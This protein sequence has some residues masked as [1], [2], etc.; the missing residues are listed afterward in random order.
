M[1]RYALFL[2]LLSLFSVL[3]AQQFVEPLFDVKAILEQDLD[4]RI[5]N[6]SVR[7]GI[8]LQEVE[9][10]SEIYQGKPVRIYGIVGFPEGAKKL[11][12]IFWSQAGMAP[13]NKGMP[14]MFAKRGYVCMCITLPHKIWNPWG[15]FNTKNP[16]DGNMTHFAIAQ[17]RA[18]TYLCSM[19]EVY[20]EK[21][22]IGG[23]SYG[24]FFSTFIAGADPRIKCG[25]SFFSG[26]NTSLGTHL[27]QF[28][29][30]ETIEDIEVWNRTID[31]VL[32]LKFRKV[33]FLWAAASNDNWF[34]LP[35]VVKT[36]QDAIGEKRLAIVPLWEH[37]FPEEVDEQLFSWFDIYLKQ[38]KKPYNS[39]S[40]LTIKK[41]RD[42]LQASWSFSG[43]Y[44]VKKAQLIVSY[45]KIELWKWWVH[46][47]YVSFPAK[48]QDNVITVE[49]PVVEP[50]LEM[51]V[52]GNIIDENGAITSTET[53]QI[54]AKDYG[55]KKANCT[56]TFNLFQWKVFDDETKK[57]FARMGL[58]RFIFDPEVKKGSPY[59]LRIEP[60]GA[61]KSTEIS[62][63]L[64][65]VPL[66]SHRLKIW[67]KTE[68]PVEMVVTVK[69]IELVDSKSQIVKLLRKQEY[70][71]KIPVFSISSDIDQN[72][73]LVELD[74]PYQNEDIEGYNLH[75]NAK[76]P[77]V[78]W[79]GSIVFEPVW[80]KN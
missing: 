70:E 28:T 60:Y 45:G 40:H 54:K 67:L 12:A 5:L 20:P 39:V 79:I 62:F 36:Y 10:T 1:N 33:P 15:A 35:S 73:K 68:K 21:I 72:W 22:G 18:I 44:E 30:L 37:G 43:H 71:S 13:A 38:A 48:I 9:F 29:N 4:A 17:M 61:R 57:N 41:S 27:P 32:R 59:S 26:G 56:T 58:N 63:K 11:P 31:P 34:Y 3:N 42:K 66:H 69:G 55:I 51:L 24:G 53:V 23:S 52:F 76:G 80:K 47:N 25:M 75:I 50:D 65:H 78:Y 19:P 74:C 7:D 49:I 16:E 6:T 8:V 64:H 77:V 2:I 46:R 14:E